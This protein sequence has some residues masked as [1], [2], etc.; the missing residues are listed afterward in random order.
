MSN[1]LKWI[2]QI[3]FSRSTVPAER[4]DRGLVN[5]G[6]LTPEQPVGIDDANGSARVCQARGSPG[7]AVAANGEGHGRLKKPKKSEAAERQKQ[8]AEASARQW[9]SDIVFLGRGVSARLGQRQCD[10][11]KLGAADLPVLATPADVARA[12][13]IGI[14]QLRWLAF[15]AEVASRV[16]YVTFTIPK[17]SGG[18]RTLS[19]PHRKLAAAQQ[20]ILGNIVA[21]LSCA[22]P[23]HG[24]RTGRS[25]LTNARPH[26]GKAVVINMDLEGFFP[27]I[28]F[29]R[30]RSVFQRL[31]YSPA[32]ATILA[33]L[34][35]ECPRQQ[36]LYDG[37]PCHVA[38]GPRA[39]PQGACTSPG[40]SNQVARRL[41]RRL[42]GL[43]AKLGLAYTRYADDLSFSG[44][45][46]LAARVGYL[47]V[48][49]RH[50][51]AKRALSSTRARRGCN[52]VTPPRRSPAW[53]STTVPASHA[54]KCAACAILHRARTEGLH[55]QNRDGRSNFCSWL[56]G[57]IAYVSMA[58]PALGARLREQLARSWNEQQMVCR[59]V[60][61]TNETGHKPG[62]PATGAAHPSL[63]L[64]DCV[65]S[66]C[67]HKK[68]KTRGMGRTSKPTCVP[69]SKATSIH[70]KWTSATA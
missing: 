43:A 4:I 12:L 3:L 56:Q 65:R 68:P 9:A 64:R 60:D 7:T 35:T 14:P 47:I 62:A 11:E 22:E 26:S 2:F 10:R 25:I 53:S 39:L 54:R 55:A 48:R 30:I 59:A 70:G 27:S 69:G 41:D 66:L 32:A 45:D 38:T 17:K 20:W 61:V 58:R 15:H 29:P 37:K 44:N 18:T 34:C 46:E 36:V 19:A 33:L 42:A 28:G 8:R 6:L 13:D 51:A 40:L 50:I 23:A 24:F 31:G 21:G 67:L 52:G 57:K 49:V 1:F 5:S 16:H 63:A